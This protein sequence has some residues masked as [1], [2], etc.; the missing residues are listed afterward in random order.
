MTY[1]FQ[2]E[3]ADTKNCLVGAHFAQDQQFFIFWVWNNETNGID[4]R[5][6]NI[7]LEEA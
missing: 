6:V 4:H 2:T 5:W 3:Y 7:W 1:T